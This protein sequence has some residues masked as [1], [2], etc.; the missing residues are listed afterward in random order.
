M[1]MKKSKTIFEVLRNLDEEIIDSPEDGYY[2][3]LLSTQAEKAATSLTIEDAVKAHT[4][5]THIYSSPE[6]K[7]YKLLREAINYSKYNFFWFH[8]F[9]IKIAEEFKSKLE[10]D[11]VTPQ[12]PEVKESLFYVVKTYL[13]FFILPYKDK[14]KIYTEQ[15]IKDYYASSFKVNKNGVLDVVENV[16]GI[17][18]INRVMYIKEDYE[19]DDFLNGYPFWYKLPTKIFERYSTKLNRRVRICYENN[20]FRYFIAGASDNW[21]EIYEVPI[22]MDIVL[23]ALLFRN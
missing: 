20:E 11:S 23:H 7:D 21:E 12:Y 13:P 2:P 4:V 10:I 3:I 15:F 5:L 19:V 17:E 22:E 18:K 8:T 9:Y 6:E 14:Y 16:P 1:L